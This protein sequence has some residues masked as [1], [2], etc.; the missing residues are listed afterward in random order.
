MREVMVLQF[1]HAE[2]DRSRAGLI[3][4]LTPL[5]QDKDSIATTIRTDYFLVELTLSRHKL[6]EVRPWVYDDTE[7]SH[8]EGDIAAMDVTWFTF[9]RQGIDR[10]TIDIAR[11]IP[12]GWPDLP[13]EQLALW[14]SQLF[15]DD[16]NP[17]LPQPFRFEG[18]SC[19]IEPDDIAHA[20]Q[21]LGDILAVDS[22]MSAMPSPSISV[23]L[24]NGPFGVAR[25]DRHGAMVPLEAAGRLAILA[26]IACEH[27]TGAA[28]NLDQPHHPDLMPRR[29]AIP[30]GG[31]TVTRRG[32]SSAHELVASFARV[33]DLYRENR[34]GWLARWRRSAPDG[35]PVDPQT[36][37]ELDRLL[38]DEDRRAA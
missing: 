8:F 25:F 32:Q 38:L 17:S 11:L 34:D 24:P 2:P 14:L 10:M 19:E 20:R 18:S 21:L 23:T 12:A 5:L 7:S 28:G 13:R 35:L 1:G 30:A 29:Q 22:I 3:A 4:G 15:L 36:I 9:L 31:I 27:I 37:E 6:L 26:H 16:I 33:A